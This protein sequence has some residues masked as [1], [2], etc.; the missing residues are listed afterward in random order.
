MGQ[1][2]PANKQAE[3]KDPK[4]KHEKHTERSL[5]HPPLSASSSLVDRGCALCLSPLCWVYQAGLQS[6]L[7]LLQVTHCRYAYAQTLTV[8]ETAA[9]SPTDPKR[10]DGASWCLCSRHTMYLGVHMLNANRSR[11]CGHTAWDKANM[12]VIGQTPSF[13]DENSK[14]E[15]SGGL[16]W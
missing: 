6:S 10:Q 1:N 15:K 3:G 7:L 9:L 8:G 12:K 13:K 2:K 11:F 14:D 5:L 4:E 16:G